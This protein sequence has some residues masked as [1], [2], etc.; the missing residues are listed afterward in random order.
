MKER[1]M[2]KWLAYRSLP[3]QEHY[4][5]QLRQE[6]AYIECPIISDSEAEAI[7]MALRNYQGELVAVRFYCNGKIRE[8]TGTIQRIDAIYKA[9]QINAMTIV[10]GN[11]LGIRYL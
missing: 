4:L 6:R 10:F 1:G 8:T 7:D 2:K 3:E 5:E 11:L 9:I